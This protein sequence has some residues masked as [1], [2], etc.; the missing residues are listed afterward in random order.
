MRHTHAACCALVVL[1]AAAGPLP[2]DTFTV[3]LSD[4][5]GSYEYAEWNSLWGEP[6]PASVLREMSVHLPFPADAVESVTLHLA[7]SAAN[8][9]VRGDGVAAEPVD[10]VVISAFSLE[11]ILGGVL[12]DLYVEETAPLQG[13]FTLDLA[14]AKHVDRAPDEPQVDGVV[15]ALILVGA[16][17]PGPPP[18]IE[19]GNGGV[20]GYNGLIM[21]VPFSATVTEAT[22]VLEGAAVPEPATLALLAAG[23]SAALARRRHGRLTAP[24]RA[25]A[26]A[27]PARTS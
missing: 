3:P 17:D 11:L 4:L 7:G 16:Y 10:A 22:L 24:R 27:P 9:L 14:L 26:P 8:G 18:D 20:G 6:P 15:S 13:P 21:V 23:A 2:A 1:L 12:Y 25:R 19:S 5:V